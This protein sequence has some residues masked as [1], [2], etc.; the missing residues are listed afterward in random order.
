MTDLGGLF[1]LP[2][3]GLLPQLIGVAP[4]KAIKLT[5]GDETVVRDLKSTSAHT[6]F[7]KHTDTRIHTQQWWRKYWNSVLW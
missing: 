3:L 4:E 2:F 6:L 1:S 5:V 7:K